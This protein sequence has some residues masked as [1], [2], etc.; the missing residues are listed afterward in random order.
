[1]RMRPSADPRA[2]GIYQSFD[3]V[4]P[5]PLVI[6][7]TRI[8]GFVGLAQKGPM[9][10]PTRLSNW[11][12]FLE[13]F[14]YSSESYLSDSVYGYFRNGGSECWVVRVAHCAPKGELPG[15]EHAACAEHV[16]IDDWDKPSM[17][18]RALNEGAWGNTI[19]FRCVHSPGAQALLTRDLDIGAGEAHVN[20]TRGFEIGALVRLFDRENSDYVVLTEVH[21]KLVK[22]GVETPVNRRHR[23]AAPTHLE[24]M[25]FEIHVAQKDRRETFKGLQ[26]HPSS[27]NYAPRVVSQRSRLVRLED[28]QTKS[29]VPHNLPEALPMTRLSG[30]RDGLDALAPDDFTGLDMGPGERSGLAALGANEEVAVL[31]APDAMRFYDKE[32]G[33]A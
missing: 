27:R 16:Q 2:P 10:E 18:I 30:G 1:M 12:E 20:A 4:A 25:T 33:P 31:A 29:P 19:W 15:I 23:A 9:N 11:D 5:P 24:V 3:S 8:C 28:M 6:A 17:K 14:G 32:P 26:M 21:D 22:W 13:H 7:N